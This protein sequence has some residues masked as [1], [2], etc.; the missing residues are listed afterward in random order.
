MLMLTN[1]QLPKK[2][3]YGSNKSFKYFVGYDDYVI[4]PL[5]IKLPQM[6]GQIKC[7]D[8]N[9]KKPFKA[10]DNKSLKKYTRIW[11]KNSSLVSIRF[12]SE[13]AYADNDIHIKFI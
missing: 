5:C 9:Q 8:S 3:P 2:E 6:I 11:K 13:S 1:Y 7:F 12:D 4:I 10:T